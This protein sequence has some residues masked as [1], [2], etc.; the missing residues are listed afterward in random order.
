MDFVSVGVIERAALKIA[1]SLDALYLCPAPENTTV[2]RAFLNLLIDATVTRQ[3]ASSRHDYVLML[4]TF[5]ALVVLSR[6][7][8]LKRVALATSLFEQFVG[9]RR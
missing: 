5:I 6:T 1:D 2:C 7:L 4:A 8:L 3:H 9:D